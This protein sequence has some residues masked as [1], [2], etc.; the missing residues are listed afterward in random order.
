MPA[1][2]PT[3]G[4][5]LVIRSGA[6]TEYSAAT[7][8]NRVRVMAWDLDPDAAW[9]ISSWFHGQLLALRGD[10]DLVSFQYDS[11]PAHGVDPDYKTPIVAFAINARMRPAI[12]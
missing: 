11:G 3:P 8:T 12:L 1:E 2:L 4:R 5:R 7:A 6:W 9:D 10:D